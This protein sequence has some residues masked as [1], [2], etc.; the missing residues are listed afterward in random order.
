MRIVSKYKVYKVFD[1]YKFPQKEFLLM[2]SSKEQAKRMAR[3]I[4][5]KGFDIMG[6]VNFWGEIEW[7]GFS[8]V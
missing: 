4:T 5:Q 1:R 7:C 6:R 8:I 2:V 3:D